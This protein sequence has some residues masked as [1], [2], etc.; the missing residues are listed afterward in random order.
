MSSEMFEEAQRHAESVRASNAAIARGRTE[1]LL[2]RVRLD[3]AREAM[4][5]SQGVSV[6]LYSRDQ[7]LSLEADVNGTVGRPLLPL[8]H[9]TYVD[10]TV[11]NEF[12]ASSLSLHPTMKLWMDMLGRSPAQVYGRESS[13][14][15]PVRETLRRC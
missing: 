2:K 8:P 7:L 1:Q 13:Y 10:D 3:R 6:P 14:S 4:D 12:H 9:A 5:H 15:I 11:S